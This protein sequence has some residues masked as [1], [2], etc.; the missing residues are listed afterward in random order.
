MNH[1][2]WVCVLYNTVPSESLTLISLSRIFSKKPNRE[3]NVLVFDNS[4]KLLGTLDFFPKNAKVLFKHDPLN[5]GLAVAYNYALNQALKLGIKWLV[6]LDQDSS[7]ELNFEDELLRSIDIIN[8]ETTVAIIP[9]VF[10]GKK[11]ISP[12]RLIFGLLHRK[13]NLISNQLITDEFSAIN[14]GTTVSVNFLA[15][16]NGFNQQFPLDLLDHWLFYTINQ[17]NKNV[18]L[19]NSIIQHSLSIID[20]NVSEHRYKLILD[21]ERELFCKIKNKRNTYKIILMLRA[22]KQ[23]LKGQISIFKLTLLALIK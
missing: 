12:T 8:A 9:K 7:L 23:I 11:L 21:A 6:L 5:P 22:I 15:S 20:G 1:I 3:Y 2:Y 17:N 19:N 14:S 16:I 10:H 13:S 18:F 4:P